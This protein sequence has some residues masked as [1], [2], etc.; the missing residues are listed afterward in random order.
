MPRVK[1]ALPSRSWCSV[2]F[3]LGKHISVLHEALPE[4]SGQC[5]GRRG[6]E[7]AILAIRLSTVN[8]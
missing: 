3:C 1:V 2:G 8:L 4:D 5:G 7:L 6:G